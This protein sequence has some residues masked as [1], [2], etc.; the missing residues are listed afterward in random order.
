MKIKKLELKSFRGLKDVE[1]NLNDKLN[2]FSGKNGIGKS[3]II[4]SIMWVL[5]DET[6]VYGKTDSDNRNQHNLKDVIN[7]VLT[8]EDGTTLERKYWDKWIEDLDGNYRF[9]KV[10]NQF[11]VNGAKFTKAKYI[12]FLKEKIGLI[13][14]IKTDK[15][16]LLRCLMDYN[17]FSS[18]ETKIS[19]DF[20]K[21]ILK[22]KSDDEILNEDR[23]AEIRNDMLLFK[24]NGKYDVV[25][26][27]NKYNAE[28]KKIGIEIEEKNTLI[29]EY[30]KNVD[31]S[32]VAEINSLVEERNI[33][34][35]SNVL[36]D[37]EYLRLNQ[38]L[39]E[40]A[41]SIREEL[42]NDLELKNSLKLEMNDLITKG[43]V[44][45]NE[46]KLAKNEI[47]NMFT[48]KERNNTMI[49]S[50][51]DY[52]L[53][54]EDENIELLYCPHC[55][56]ILNEEEN[57]KFQEK[58]EKNIVD[59]KNKI[60]NYTQENKEIEQKTKEL[61]NKILEYEK[62]KKLL[63]AKYYEKE[64]MLKKLEAKEKS[65]KLVELENAKIEIEKQIRDYV[66]EFSKDKQEKINANL[67]KYNEYSA[68]QNNI[69][70][71]NKL[72]ETLKEK[73]ITKATLENR[74]DIA[75]EFKD[76]TLK[77][78]E[79]NT[80]NV[81]PKLEIKIV[82]VSENTGAISN[83]CYIKL[84]DVEYKGINDGHRKYA[85]IM[86]IEDVKRALELEDLPIVFDKFADIDSEMLETINNLT[87]AQIITTKVSED[88]EI[89]LY[90]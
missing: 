43:N 33:L 30:Q 53:K 39:E 79:E 71:I 87:N 15:F 41:T 86:F 50:L 63:G 25:S 6:L 27:I 31:E 12:N 24:T 20:I 85:G 11:F 4:D 80:K 84:K 32:K 75:I 62:S 7:V 5:C 45:V 8:L 17:Y 40:K 26:C 22:L 55:N 72:K 2:I 73:K 51:K 34:I 48:N 58:K 88:K 61:E 76:Y 49:D 68:I 47:D 42:K 36:K 16:N 66:E 78:I 37:T 83:V 67:E 57:K 77:L 46:I 29:K 13:N 10:E 59:L 90:E 65:E 54:L 19:R 38:L 3:T 28:I 52:I 70:Q 82:E 64:N 69:I 21:E 81:F 18:V 1:Y 74:K 44:V 89:K 60:E 56:G 9:D 23:F 35:N 14:D